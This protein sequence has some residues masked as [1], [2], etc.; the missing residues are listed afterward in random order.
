MLTRLLIGMCLIPIVTLTVIT[1]IL[2]P[3]KEGKLEAEVTS[4][5]LPP[6]EYYLT[7]YDQR[8]PFT[9]GEL[10]VTNTS[11]VDWTHLDIQINGNYNIH[12]IKPIPAGATVQ[13]RLD[14]FITRTGARFSLRYNQLKTVRIYARR[15]T[16]DRATFYHE[17]ETVPE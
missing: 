7:R 9:G 10:I 2:P 11:D 12:D 8:P 17:F 4:S 14:R 3:T 15:P 16:R 6:A 1:L 13:F 5:G